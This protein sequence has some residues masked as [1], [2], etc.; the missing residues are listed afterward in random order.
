[1]GRVLDGLTQEPLPGATITYAPGKG[2]V[3]N[4]DGEYRLE[5]APGAYT[6][7]Y[8]FVG[9]ETKEVEI[10][11]APGETLNRIIR[12]NS[13]TLKEVSIVADIA[14]DRKTPVAFSNISPKQIE[15]ELGS[16]DIP[17]IL[18][19]TPGVYA[20]QQGGGDGDARI[21][22]RGFDQTNI[23]VMI[24]GI[25]VND[26][27]NRRV[28]WSNWFGLD[29]VTANIQVQRG[30]GASKLALPAIGGTLNILTRGID[31]KQSTR[32]R[33]EFGSGNFTR[34]TFMHN[35]GKLENGWGY[36]ISGS[37]K[38]GDGMVDGTFTEGAF[39]YFKVEKLIDRH[40]ISFTGFGAP[41]RHGQRTF[42]G[43]IAEFSHDFAERAGVDQDVI[44]N[45][46][47]RGR[48]YNQHWGQYE[49]YSLMGVVNNPLPP[50]FIS[51]PDEYVITGRGQLNNVYERQNFYHKP[52]FTV[53]DFWQ[54][55]NDLSIATSAYLSTGRG[56]G[57]QLR[58]R[59]GVS[60]T[61]AGLIDFQEYHDANITNDFK[62]EFGFLNVDTNFHPTDIR[63]G[64]YIRVARND[65]FWTGML[66]QAN[67]RVSD[68][69]MLAAGIDFRYYTGY[70]YSE[71]HQFVGGDYYIDN[72]DEN[73]P[74][75]AVKREGDRLF[76]DQEAHVAWGGG[77]MQA[78]YTDGPLTITANLTAAR[79]GF[80]GRDHYRKRILDVNDSTR[81]EVGYRDTVQVGDQVFTRDSPGLRTY[82]TDWIWVN[83]FTAKIGA[84]YDLTERMN[85][86]ANTGFMSI[87]PIFAN[88]IDRNFDP[89]NEFFNE[90]ISAVELGLQYG[91]KKFSGNM[92][93]Y[94]TYWGNRPVS[95]L[96]PVNYPVNGANGDP[97]EDTFAFVR[98]V[99]ALHMGIEF[100]GAYKILPW[101]KVDFLFSIGNWTWQSEERAN[102]VQGNVVIEDQDGNPLEFLIDPRGVRVGDAAQTQIGGALEVQPVK[103]S[104]IRAR[105]LRFSD[106]YSQFQPESV[107]G[108][109]AGR[110]SWRIPDYTLVELHASYTFR[111]DKSNLRVGAS[112]FNLFDV[113]FI[114]DAQNND[115]FTRF[116]N[117]Q[118]F[119]AASAGVFPGLGRRLNFNVTFEI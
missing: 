70:Q 23:A 31:S 105:V 54:V 28:F 50:P 118:N 21:N 100:E 66:S 4:M 26:M 3:T 40:R 112:C 106:N 95:R 109:N 101:L 44:N 22:I 119:D 13:L 18:N 60:Q 37:Y 111:F 64:E 17:M 86:Y 84:N 115:T 25:P 1:M 63:T 80:M 102:Y 68:N 67:Y 51:T 98:S 30:L 58:S 77:F 14:R 20:T 65:H 5:L 10:T 116:T 78:E 47:D 52:Q 33:Q 99:D 6:M 81:I 108:V 88:V 114:S 97:S 91:S 74:R 89:F 53:R 34:S 9:F 39:Y 83:G 57:T 12:L 79:T 75:N 107:T 103:N 7:V 104:F 2:M 87:A 32:F 96:V 56:G 42:K 94:Y 24:D 76:R 92:N 117:S 59:S 46:P 8:S 41:Q 69:L 93:A 27:Q 71:V 43:E 82:Q 85:I 49:N 36:T 55:N 35:S 113:F 29:L 90:Q 15:E 48:Y 62:P 45:I 38:N 16:Q 19:H 61:G 11:L 110:Q 73:A 72:S